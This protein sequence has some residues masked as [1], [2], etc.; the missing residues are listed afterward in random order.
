MDII[1]DKH[2]SKGRLYPRPISTCTE[3]GN[4]MVLC[5][6]DTISPYWRHKVDQEL[7]NPCN[8]RGEGLT[9]KLAK[10]QIKEYLDNGGVI[11]VIN[12]CSLC[13]VVKKKIYYKNKDEEIKLEYKFNS[14]IFDLVCLI[15][16]K[17]KFGIEIRDSHA[18][19]K[20][21]ER[22]GVDWIELDADT[23][24]SFLDLQPVPK[25]FTI[26]NI[27]RDKQILCDSCH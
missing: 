8:G 7:I 4:P 18:V 21:R 19:E 10:E 5:W 12:Q 16:T 27:K 25:R 22:R 24:L 3:C 13:R 6:G 14:I 17:I 26:K 11:D 23:L 15:D 20:V 2:L 1:K 9:H